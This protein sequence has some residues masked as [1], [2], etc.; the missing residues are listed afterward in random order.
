MFDSLMTFVVVLLL[1]VWVLDALGVLELF[2]ALFELG[3]AVVA[4]VLFL[5]TWAIRKAIAARKPNPPLPSP[6]SRP[7]GGRAGSGGSRKPPSD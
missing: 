1:L 3:S 5:V 6:E 2:S 7:R 4:G